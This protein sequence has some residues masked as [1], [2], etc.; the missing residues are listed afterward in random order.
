MKSL[1]LSA[2]KNLLALVILIFVVLMRCGGSSMP[3]AGDAYV[4]NACRVTRYRSL[5]IQLLAPYSSYAKNNPRRWAEVGVIVTM[6]EAKNVSKFLH[7]LKVH[8]HFRRR[9]RNALSDCIECLQE[10][11]DNLYESLGELK[12]LEARTF[13]LQMENV[14][15][16][17]SAALTDEDTCLD[18]FDG[19][20]GKR[21]KML[22]N[23]LVKVS[24]ITSIALALV[25]ELASHHIREEP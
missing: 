16:Y 4:R 5:C 13:E 14:E 7:T 17:M 22:Q 6:G 12:H 9:Q 2:M 21:V 3:K 1:K 19:R 20:K 15:T 23:K 8:V 18:G 24:H 25:T 10:T 11:L